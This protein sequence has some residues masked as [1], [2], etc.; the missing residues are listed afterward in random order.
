[1]TE[2]LQQIKEVITG[3]DGEIESIGNDKKRKI[4]EYEGNE[5]FQLGHT[6]YYKKLV[7]N[8]CLFNQEEAKHMLQYYARSRNL[9]DEKEEVIFLQK[10]N[11]N[12][13]PFASQDL[14]ENMIQ[15]C[16]VKGYQ[17][18]C[19]QIPE[20]IAYPTYPKWK[21]DQLTLEELKWLHEHIKIKS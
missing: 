20:F 4:G 5:I 18:S 7:L 3:E 13:N 17:L 1:M 11:Q 2:R 9:L 12:E 21:R 19:T 14:M 10:I 6:L 16:K 8:F 15:R